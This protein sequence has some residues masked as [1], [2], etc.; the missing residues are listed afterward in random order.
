MWVCEMFEGFFPRKWEQDF[1]RYVHMP[2]FGEKFTK[3]D[4]LIYYYS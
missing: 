2:V 1:Q 3:R 4:L